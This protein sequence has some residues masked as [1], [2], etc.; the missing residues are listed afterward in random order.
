M[1]VKVRKVELC[2]RSV[3]GNQKHKVL[4]VLRGVERI[5]AYLQVLAPFCLHEAAGA[6]MKR[7]SIGTQRSQFHFS[8]PYP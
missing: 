4:K 2:A 5:S 1:K 3:D 6:H 8:F 7:E